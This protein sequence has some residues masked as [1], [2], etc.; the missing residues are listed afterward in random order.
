MNVQ[1]MIDAKLVHEI[2]TSGRKSFR[3]CRRRWDWVFN[4][5]YYPIMTAKPLEFGTAF[6]AGMETYYEPATW[7]MDREVVGQLAI[8]TFVDKCESQLAKAL[9]AREQ[10]SLDEDVQQD[11]DERVE[12]G[13]GMM[14]YYFKSIAPKIDKGWKPVRVE[15]AF[16]LPIPNPETGEPVIWC[17]CQQCNDKVMVWRRTRPEFDAIDVFPNGL[18]VVYAGRLDMLAED[19]NGNYWIFD[20]K[21]AR[22]ISLDDEFLYLDD[23]IASYVW[24]LRKLGLN[25]RGFVY[26]EQRKG[27]PQPPH[28]NAAR[29]KGCLF[30]VNKQ[31]DVDYDTYLKH[32]K[33]F[34]AVAYG[35]GCYDAMLE[36][37]KEEGI[38]YYA[39]HQIHKSDEEI[40]STEAN[41]GFEAL[42]MI[43]PGL[44]IYPSPGRFGCN[45][46]AFRQPCMEKNAGGDYLY[47]L[48]T[49]FEQRAHYYVRAE[50]STESKGGE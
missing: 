46:C 40:A 38:V 9:A 50:P 11:Y 49:M 17:R 12:L 8:K 48:D 7:G 45:F 32:V 41:I 37:L 14:E 19:E 31:Q 43:D 35:E 18:P 16:M 24:A 13:R 6:H 42:D 36:Y 3:A 4:Q 26:H 28:E 34:D 21:T 1:E 47:A 22:S 20:W 29:R 23:Q 2:H 10:N 33:E 44:R 39:R 30:S 25:I 15:I 5:S 27:F